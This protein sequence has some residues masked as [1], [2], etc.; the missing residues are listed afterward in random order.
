MVIL[1]FPD[2]KVGKAHFS[3]YALIAPYYYSFADGELRIHY[4]SDDIIARFEVIDDYTVIFK[5]AFVPLFADVG[6]RY[7]VAPAVPPVDGTV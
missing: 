6:A 4:E 1:S 5:E 3:S 2:S 7:V